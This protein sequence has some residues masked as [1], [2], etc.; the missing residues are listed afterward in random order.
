[1][2]QPEVKLESSWGQA[3]VSLGSTGVDVGST[4]GQPAVNPCQSR[5]KPGA[6]P[7]STWGRA[8]AP[9]PE[10]ARVLVLD[11]VVRAALRGQGHHY[12]TIRQCGNESM[13]AKEKRRSGR[14]EKADS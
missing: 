9:Y 14:A 3:G 4:W 8:A 10:P 6:Y 1:L 2:G 13:R 12:C 7:G 11:E 5:V